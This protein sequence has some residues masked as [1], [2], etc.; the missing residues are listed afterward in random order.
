[1]PYLQMEKTAN[2]PEAAHVAQDSGASGLEGGEAAEFASN[3]D[4]AQ[5]RVVRGNLREYVLPTAVVIG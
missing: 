1:M 3:G 2:A 4:N 5:V